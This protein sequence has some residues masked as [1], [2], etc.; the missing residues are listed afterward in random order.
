MRRD[1]KL[2]LALGMLVLG[3]ACA[4]CFPRQRASVVL[5]QVVIPAP[6][7]DSELEFLPI[8]AYQPAP[9]VA[10]SQRSL[11]EVLPSD[12]VIPGEAPPP[13]TPAPVVAS[14]E[15]TPAAVPPVV[16]PQDE[17]LRAE[18]SEQRYRVRS[19]DTLTAIASRLLGDGRRYL[20]IY[21]ANAQTL[22]S[23]DNLAVGTEL[24]IPPKLKLVALS[25]P[26]PDHAPAKA[27]TPEPAPTP[28][29]AQSTPR[30][31]TTLPNTVPGATSAP[32]DVMLSL[33]A[34]NGGVVRTHTVKQGETLESIA[35]R[36]Y[37]NRHAVD[38]LRSHNPALMGN[39]RQLQA[40]MQLLIK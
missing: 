40:G 16:T 35:V 21:E 8:R 25:P 18:T 10:D 39:P 23:P 27:A 19:G 22:G 30:S 32:R 17:A 33:P 28:T 20:E 2:G 38:R 37:G 31:V 1:A 3:F 5:E 6:I 12:P 29:L 9:A 36:Y 4:F 11:A 15:P 34:N 13:L 14:Q 24:R 7:A 26:E